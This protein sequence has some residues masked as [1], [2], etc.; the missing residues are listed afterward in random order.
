MAPFVCHGQPNS[1]QSIYD[2]SCFVALFRTVCINQL[3]QRDLY[4][5]HPH[6][7]TLTLHFFSSY[8]KRTRF[9]S[10]AE[11]RYKK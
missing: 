11:K 7:I 4:V 9:Y 2:S 5:I 10:H 3:C 1:N 8:A 6:Q